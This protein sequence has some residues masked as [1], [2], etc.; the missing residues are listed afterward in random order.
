MLQRD[1]ADP[2]KCDR[3]LPVCSR[4][5]AAKAPCTGVS[6]IDSEVQVPRSLIQF[7][8]SQIAQWEIELQAQ[9]DN[10]LVDGYDNSDSQPASE[11]D[12]FLQENED[13]LAILSQAAETFEETRILQATGDLES[14]IIRSSEFRSMVG[15]TMPTDPALTD[16][17]SRVRMGL[18]P[19]AVLP[20]I[21]VQSPEPR[22]VP[23]PVSSEE[24]WLDVA[25][26]AT[27]PEHV[28]QTL[29]RKYI[30]Y[31]FPLSPVISQ[32]EVNESLGV[33]LATMR[34]L[35]N[36]STSKRVRPSFPFLATYLVLAISSTLGCAKTQHESRCLAFSE[37]LFN[38]GISHL[39]TSLQ[40]P[41]DL[42][43]LQ[44]TLLILQYAEINPKCANIWILN[45]ASMRS[46][47]ELGLHR[48]PVRPIALD[49]KTVELRRR[50]FWAAYCMDRT[51][52]PAL[53]RPLYI[54]D[55]LI[56]A[57]LPGFPKQ[58][59]EEREISKHASLDWIGYCR[60]QSEVSEVHF[61]GKM[62][63]R[64]W[65]SWLVEAESKLMRWYR[66]NL[67]A[68]E[69]VEFAYAQGL[70]R[71]HRPSPR[72][73]MPST[74]SLVTAFEAAS[75]AAKHNREPILNGF[76]R[77][78]W[79]AAHNTAETA[80]VAVF[81]LRHAFDEISLRYSAS[82]IFD[83]TKVFT[84]NLLALAAHGWPEISQFAATFE[85]LLA[86]LINGIMM[87]TSTALLMYPS[88]LE[89]ELD[90]FLLPG[91][92]RKETFFGNGFPNMLDLS[93]FEGG[94][95]EDMNWDEAFLETLAA[96]TD[97][98]NWD[99]MTLDH[100]EVMNDFL[101]PLS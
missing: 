86:P 74:E 65:E 23:I 82:E 78:P 10:G 97:P 87:K 73:S 43:S 34:E 17:V 11:G 93:S 52:S 77:K 57:R 89:A 56:N 18:T 49:K 41:N 21:T 25:T 29:V 27:L 28:V 69:V 37:V 8:E 80:M 30:R 14:S 83:K 42:A 2:V 32:E 50:L 22:R 92:A 12:D 66:D 55:D 3:R 94:L 47:L 44:A 63:D 38:E 76:L 15:A 70:V 71:I 64:D 39:T 46:C 67:S 35:R 59:V 16:L 90:Q 100:A 53:Q 85:R 26:L 6:T 13:P 96:T 1:E 81:C 79:L 45:G 98:Y 19:S 101:S 99:H 4:C 20:I 95:G 40:Y 84:S 75:R 61:Q 54:P 31:V 72:R 48:E 9:K 68:D 62:L 91:P 60:I 88:S 36:R 5:E 7:L 24:E 51:I 58:G 33:V